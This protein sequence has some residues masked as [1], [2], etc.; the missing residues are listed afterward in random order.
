MPS[1]F[2][3]VVIPASDAALCADAIR[4]LRREEFEGILVRGV[5]DADAC[6]WLCAALE[7]GRHGLLRTDFPPPFHAF[8]F[9][10]NLNLTSPDLSAYFRAAPVFREQLAGLFAG[11]GDLE[12]RVTG[13]LSALDAG[14][15]YVAAPG[16]RPG[17]DHM[18]TTLR[19]HRPGGFIPQHFDDE[20]EARDSYRLITP[21]LV[22]DVFSFVLAFS[23][24]E[25]GGELEVFN[26]RHRGRRFRMADGPDDARHLSVEGVES[27]RFRLAPGEMIIINSGR[28]LHRVTPVIGTATR[29]TACSFMAESRT[30]DVLC[31]G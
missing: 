15:R 25:A 20:H 4:Q 23:Q 1:F 28:Y 7:D 30:G 29:W 22:S 17:V 31:W 18:F 21:S 13:L 10:M 6:A 26:L 27:V 19:A 8:F 11:V 9:G 5:Y 24:A 14:R 3:T 16:P 12:T 2:R